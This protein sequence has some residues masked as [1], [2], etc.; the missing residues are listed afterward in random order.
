VCLKWGSGRNS[1]CEQYGDIQCKWGTGS[2]AYCYNGGQE[3]K[4]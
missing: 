3:C 2:D 4:N 1:P